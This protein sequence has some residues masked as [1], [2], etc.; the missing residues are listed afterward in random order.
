MSH[1]PKGVW[2]LLPGQAKEMWKG[3]TAHPSE[4][5]SREAA[6]LRKAKILPAEIRDELKR[7]W[8]VRVRKRIAT[9]IERARKEDQKHRLARAISLCRHAAGRTT[10]Y[11]F[12]YV[13]KRTMQ[14]VVIFVSGRKAVVKVPRASRVDVLLATVAKQC[15]N[16]CSTRFVT[17][18]GK[19]LQRNRLLSDYNLQSGSLLIESPDLRGG[20]H[21]GGGTGDGAGAGFTGVGAGVGAGSAHAGQQDDNNYSFQAAL[22]ASLQQPETAS[23]QPPIAVKQAGSK[24]EYE[25]EGNV[26][27]SKRR[28][29]AA[30]GEVLFNRTYVHNRSLGF[31]CAGVGGHGTVNPTTS[32]AEAGIY[33][34]RESPVLFPPCFVSHTDTHTHTHRQ[35]ANYRRRYPAF[36]G[37][38]IQHSIEGAECYC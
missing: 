14:L 24:R 29:V 10:E 32:T 37:K 6:E 12:Q 2:S 25:G 1:K 3:L 7:V 5:H 8:I 33:T 31:I 18:S 19:E 16:M 13:K 11:R 36:C 20:M 26:H 21:N 22:M 38:R 9:A 4:E 23:T 28:G 30:D 35:R 15:Q 17:A 27:D 34:S